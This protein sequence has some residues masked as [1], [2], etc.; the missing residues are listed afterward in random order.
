MA[1]QNEHIENLSPE[2]FEVV[3]GRESETDKLIKK[4]RVVLERSYA[5]LLSK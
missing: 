3:G 4:I 2:M 1:N 5:S